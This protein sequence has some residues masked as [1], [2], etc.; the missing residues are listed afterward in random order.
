MNEVESLRIRRATVVDIPIIQDIAYKAWPKAFA[1][2]LKQDQIDYMLNWMYSEEGLERQLWIQNHL[3]AL[4]YLDEIPVGFVGYE[5]NL[6]KTQSTK[7]H[8]LYL[9]PETIGKGIGQAL[10]N[11]VQ[12]KA[13]NG[14]NTSL[15]LNVNKF[16][17]AV[18]FYKKMGFV[19]IKEEVIE[20]GKGYI[21]D[22]Y[23]MQ[24]ELNQN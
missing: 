13:I 23:V 17:K 14:E 19:I 24:K 10:L 1:S 5:H 18:D 12:E 2:I 4:A 9:L 21:M 20:I 16:N 6:N 8:K 7:I 11:Y 22:D 15:V 3:F